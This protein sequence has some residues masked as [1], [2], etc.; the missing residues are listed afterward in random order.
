MFKILLWL[1]LGWACSISHITVSMSSE[2][3]GTAVMVLEGGATGN[4]PFP[5]HR[6]QR[7]LNSDCQI[8]HHVFPQ[9]KGIIVKLKQ[10]NALKKKFVMNACQA[11]HKELAT[12]G[13]PAGP[14]KCKDCHSL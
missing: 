14:T 9:V 11:C 1:M 4:V 8:C 2:N 7:A 6:H 3:L 12:Q 10:E 5:H 13:K